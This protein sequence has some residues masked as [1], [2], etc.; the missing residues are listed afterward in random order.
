MPIILTPDSLTTLVSTDRLTQNAALATLNA[1]NPTLV[2]SLLAAAT[3]AI[4]R[5]TK[6]VI[7]SASYAEYVSGGNYPYD[8]IFFA[9]FPVTA[10]T[11]VA[12]N[13]QAVLTV[14]NSDSTSNQRATIATTSTGLT[15]YR[16][17]SGVATTSQLTSASYPT[18]QALATA[19]TALGHGWTASVAGPYASHPTADLRPLQGAYTALNGG[20]SLEMF[21]EE[22]TGPFTESDSRSWGTTYGWRL[23][24]GAG[25]LFGRFPHGHLNVRVDYTAGFE[26]IPDDLQE[27]CCQL[28][29]DFYNASLTNKSLKSE[30]VGPYAYELATMA[31]YM[32]PTVRSICEHYKD[33]GKLNLHR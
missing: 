11:R 33:R 32:S 2:A 26:V 9:E 12:T 6:R 31:D 30:R 23:D 27:A 17:S 3:T 19:I 7:F 20:A 29:G 21:L 14:Y 24:A 18:L 15:L 10:V 5:Y 8:Q 16:L 28:V 1:A 13:P 4:Q 22:V 25:I